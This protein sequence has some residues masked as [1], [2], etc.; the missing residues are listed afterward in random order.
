MAH[1]HDPLRLPPTTT[2]WLRHRLS[3]ALSVPLTSSGSSASYSLLGPHFCTIPPPPMRI[4]V[5]ALPSSSVSLPSGR[6][7]RGSWRGRPLPSLS[8]TPR[9]LTAMA[10]RLWC[11]ILI[12]VK[13]RGRATDGPKKNWHK[14]A[15]NGTKW[16]KTAQNRTKPHKTAQIFVR[17][18][19]LWFR[20]SCPF[21]CW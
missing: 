11:G 15:Q 4:V 14:T 9:R 19:L 10:N 17:A 7:A 12:H 20:F 21:F 5:F 13:K 6:R 1:R 8:C 16:H 2:K 18:K 3:T